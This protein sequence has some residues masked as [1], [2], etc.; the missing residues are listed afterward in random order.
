MMMQPYKGYFIEGTALLVHPFSPDWYVGGS[1]LKQGRS[2]SIV[3]I[4]RFQLQRFTV[5][6]K[7]VAEW[8]GVEL[9]RIAVDELLG[10]AK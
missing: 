4:G 10:L 6:T 1:V 8:F 5:D 7:A 9:A 3:E 2:T